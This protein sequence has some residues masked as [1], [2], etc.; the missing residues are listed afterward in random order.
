MEIIEQQENEKARG[1]RKK[2]APRPHPVTI[3]EDLC[4][5]CAICVNVCPTGVLVIDDCKRSVFGLIAKVE[6]PEYCIGC[7]LCELHCPD[8]AIFVDY[9]KRKEEGK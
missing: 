3:K 7:M 8:F 5:G 2:P 4:K 6:A 9:D 1:R